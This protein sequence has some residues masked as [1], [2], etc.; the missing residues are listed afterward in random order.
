MGPESKHKYTLY[1][2]GEPLSLATLPEIAVPPDAPRPEVDLPFQS[3]KFTVRFKTPKHWRCRNRKRF[4]KLMMGEGWTRN[5]A[6]AL[7][8]LVRG[9]KIPYSEAWKSHLRKRLL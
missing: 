2:N 3:V 1:Y 5:W 9:S 6:E 7:A 4:I 8:H